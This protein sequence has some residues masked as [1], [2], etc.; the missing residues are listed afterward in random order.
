MPETGYASAFG[1]QWL[2]YR[3]TQLDSHTGVPVSER[4]L[5]RCLGHDLW[6]TLEGMNVLEAGCGAGRFTEVLLDRRANVTS[7]DL[8]MAVEANNENFPVSD[9]HRI[10]QADILR[11]PFARQQFDAVVCVGVVQHTPSPEH[12]IEALY[13]QVQPGGWLVIDH[14]TFALSY[15]TKLAP[16]FRAVLKRMEPGRGLRATEA[17]V[18]TFL[19]LHKA[20]RHYYPGQ[21]LLSRASPVIVYYHAIP[22]LSDADQ[23][24]WA[25]LDTHDSLTDW[26]KH[27]RTRKQL[28][29]LLE[30]LGLVDIYCDYG[31]TGVEARGRRPLIHDD[32]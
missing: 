21:A 24:Q 20:V 31:G 15:F 30:R 4:R 29:V 7:I 2:R 9:F 25:L 8:S 13:Q 19:P 16:V 11:L 28:R 10:A 12:T 14:Y 23:E 17:L 26:Y 32:Q 5:R 6:S 22:E 1:A 3:V 27:F 18:R